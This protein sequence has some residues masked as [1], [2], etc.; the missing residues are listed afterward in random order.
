MCPTT[1]SQ[2]TWPFSAVR[3]VPRPRAP[4][5]ANTRNPTL[6]TFVASGDYDLATPSVA[7]DFTFNHLGL[8]PDLREHVTIH[9]YKS[10]H[11]MYIHRPS[12]L[13][14]KADLREFYEGATP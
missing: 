14:L 2:A 12:M 9:Y 6:R 8:D 5:Q 1:L 11:M 7:T 10:G 4:R 13:Q 3:A